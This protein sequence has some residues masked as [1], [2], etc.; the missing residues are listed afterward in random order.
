MTLTPERRAEIEKTV[1]ANRAMQEAL[2]DAQRKGVPEV[3]IS[4]V[5]SSDDPPLFAA[6]S[7]AELR[8]VRSAFRDKGIE[9][10]APFMTMDAVDASGGYIGEFII[11][12]AQI[13]G[14]VIA[15][16]VGAWLQARS[17][18]KVRVKVKDIEIEATTKEAMTK[19]EFEK[20]L[21][22]LIEAQS[23]MNKKS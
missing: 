2:S 6:E 4:L 1:A 22:R 14:P 18:R 12:L 11:P 13:V 5:R 10:A 21:D 3:K 19:E 23:K 8:S 16:I 17:G 7:Q 9:A 20:F 15:G